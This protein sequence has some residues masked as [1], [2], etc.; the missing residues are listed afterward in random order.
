MTIQLS[1]VNTIYCCSFWLC[2]NIIWV[3]NDVDKGQIHNMGNWKHKLV[4][5]TL[6]QIYSNVLISVWMVI[7]DLY[8]GIAK[9]LAWVSPSAQLDYTLAVWIDLVLEVSVDWIVA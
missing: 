6:L 9:L 3:R 1:F 2:P 8:K 4:C 7:Q 5:G